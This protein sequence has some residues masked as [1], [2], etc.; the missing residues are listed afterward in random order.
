MKPERGAKRSFIFPISSRAKP[1][2]PTPGSEL[3]S[4]PVPTEE[5]F[6]LKSYLH[7]RGDPAGAAQGFAHAGGFVGSA[8]VRARGMGL[9]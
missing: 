7:P 5:R 8:Q 6:L 4:R 9:G 2:H 3:F 1:F